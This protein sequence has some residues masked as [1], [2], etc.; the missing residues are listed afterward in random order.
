MRDRALATDYD[1]TLAQEGQVS[2][3]TVLA[4][5]HLRSSGRKII[6]VTGRV[7]SDLRSVCPRLDQFDRVVAE[8]GALLYNPGTGEERPLGLP[9]PDDL[10]ECLRTAGCSPL[11][12]GRVI[13]ATREPHG[14]AVRDIIH[15]MGLELHVIHNQ[16]AVM[17]L[18]RGV[19]KSTGLATALDELGLSLQETVA[20][21]DDENDLAMLD[22]CACG[23]AVA[24][25][26]PILKHGARIVMQGSR[27]Q[28]VEELIARLLVDNV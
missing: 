23:V 11:G 27:G 12:V 9:P 26:L 21:G 17:I 20:I 2:A 5:E 19:D 6:L 8:N 18:P 7:L 1:E 24:N 22:A 14:K 3:T 25:A 28:G 4:L 16:G 10:V 13:V 15:A